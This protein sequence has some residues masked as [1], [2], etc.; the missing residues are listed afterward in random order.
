MDRQLLEVR[1]GYPKKP[2]LPPSPTDAVIWHVTRIR[3]VASGIPGPLQDR[4][5]NLANDLERHAEEI[6]AKEKD[7]ALR[8]ARFTFLADR[9]G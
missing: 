3:D 6:R 9:L 2:M 5:N 8:R 7:L 4:L 1:G